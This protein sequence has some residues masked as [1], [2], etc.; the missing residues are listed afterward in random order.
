MTYHC[1]EIDCNQDAEFEIFPDPQENF[2]D[3]T[4][5]CS[6]HVGMLLGST[7]TQ[8]VDFFRVHPLEA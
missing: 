8:K 6:L 5:S 7:G 4:L 3:S 1:C 2:E